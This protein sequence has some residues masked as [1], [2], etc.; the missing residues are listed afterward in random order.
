MPFAT[1]E[2]QESLKSRLPATVLINGL[3]AYVRDYVD[4]SIQT[5]PGHYRPLQDDA[6]RKEI[7]TTL[8]TVCALCSMRMDDL[9]RFLSDTAYWKDSDENSTMRMVE[10]ERLHI[11]QQ[12]RD[13]WALSMS[14]DHTSVWRSIFEKFQNMHS[15]GAD[16]FAVE[17]MLT[18]MME[19]SLFVDL[20]RRIAVEVAAGALRSAVLP[21]AS[22]DIDHS[23]IGE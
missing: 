1:R 17:T 18:E 15:N 19:H 12:L 10:T 5:Q 13:C 6:H 16:E 2:L 22:A 3:L 23:D 11:H 14:A 20:V 21:L 9:R 8:H 4:H 7:L